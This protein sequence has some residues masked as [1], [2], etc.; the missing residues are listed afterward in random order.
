MDKT[1]MLDTHGDPLGAVRRLL[2]TLWREVELDGLLVPQSDLETG[3]APHI[4][5]DPSELSQVNPF[6]PLMMINGAKVLPEQIRQHPQDHLG[7]LLRPCEM[8][9][10][11]EMV[12]HDSFK[13][14]HL[15]TI[16]VDC[17]GTYPASDFEWRA[18]RKLSSEALTKEALQFARQGGIVAYRFR[19]ACQSCASQ[20]AVGA[21]INI[22]V[23]GLPVRQ[24]I[25]VQA[26]DDATVERFK[27]ARITDG[28]AELTS[29]EQRERLLAKMLERNSHAR[30]RVI[31]GLLEVMPKNTE[32][33]AKRFE[34][35]GDC[36]DCMSICP[37]C[38]VEFPN[39]AADGSSSLRSIERW[40]VSCS[41]CGMCEQACPNHWPLNAYFGHLRKQVIGQSGYIPGRS[42]DEPLPVL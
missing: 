32:E 30:D 39:R 16:S 29:I 11:V 26:R 36:Q 35:C 23:L 14:D 33:L 15:L 10:L 22:A 19:S 20:A 12:K 5:K 13:V 24:Y 25:L 21:D 38:E 9:A 7:V 17:L 31:Q 41:G 3:A 34:S 42:L 27:L 40:M 37:I 8:R 1:W 6:R 2:H 18:E 4:L 28:P